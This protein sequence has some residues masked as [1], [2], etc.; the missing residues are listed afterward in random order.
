[1]GYTYNLRWTIG[2]GSNIKAASVL[3]TQVD[4]TPTSLHI[5]TCPAMGDS[6]TELISF[7]FKEEE[8]KAG[9]AG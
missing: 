3:W 8:G 5:G 6:D 4:D 1:M 7:L 2:K 9:K